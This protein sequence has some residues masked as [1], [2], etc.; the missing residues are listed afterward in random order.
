[1]AAASEVRWC[2]GIDLGDRNSNYCF[3]D[4]GG[5]IAAEGTMATT[6]E[7]LETLFSALGKCR[8]ALE[9]ETHSVSLSGEVCIPRKLR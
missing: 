8:I 3:L 2:I 6:Q 9:V 5:P 4:A 1:M 7:E